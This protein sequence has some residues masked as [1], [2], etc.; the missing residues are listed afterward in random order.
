MKLFT[1]KIYN[2]YGKIINAK[3]DLSRLKE[4]LVWCKRKGYYQQALTIV[5][6]I[7]P[8]ALYK[9]GI[10]EIND[11]ASKYA[12]KKNSAYAPG[13]LI[14]NDMVIDNL[15]KV[16]ITSYSGTAAKAVQ[17]GEG[18]NIVDTYATQTEV[19]KRQMNVTVNYY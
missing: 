14:F 2:D 6:G 19:A 9:S 13:V 11:V 17:D 12:R 16:P 18:N 7:T 15:A 5:E 3:D 4:E 8:F 1:D 10:F